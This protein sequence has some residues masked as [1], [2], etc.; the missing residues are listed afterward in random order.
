MMKHIAILASGAGT[1]AENIIRYFSNDKRAKVSLVLSNRSQAKVLERAAALGVEAFFFDRSQFYDTGE[2]LMML[3]RRETD[4]LV[5]AGFLWL[6]PGEVIEAFRGRIINIHP[7]LLPRF[8]GKGMYGDTVHRAVLDAGC[9]E[10]GITI[11]YVNE[12]YDSGD[13]IFQARCPVLPDDDVHTLAERVH[14]LEYR[15]Y[16]EVIGQ[17]IGDRREEEGSSDALRIKN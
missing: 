12:Q 8:G 17:L 1:N 16:P 6:V 11:H 15:H 5:L 13:I 4:L 14:A 7:A 9:S 3:L 10:S 2:V